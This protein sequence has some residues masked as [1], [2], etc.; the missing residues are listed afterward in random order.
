M[1][2]LLLQTII[3]N[4]IGIE[5]CTQRQNVT[6]NIFSSSTAGKMC[7]FN[8]GGQKLKKTMVGMICGKGFRFQATVKARGLMY[9]EKY[10]FLTDDDAMKLHA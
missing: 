10:I 3:S 4:Q 7:S 6:Q 1:F 5:Q 2:P 8:Q 9:K